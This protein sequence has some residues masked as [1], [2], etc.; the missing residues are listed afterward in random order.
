MAQDKLSQED[1]A[2]ANSILYNKANSGSGGSVKRSRILE[3]GSNSSY[4][5]CSTAGNSTAAVIDRRSS[6]STLGKWQEFTGQQ[7]LLVSH[8]W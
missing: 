4:D 5:N 2:K 6:T 3:C 8:V 1:I 7:S